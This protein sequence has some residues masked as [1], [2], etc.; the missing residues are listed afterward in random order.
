LRASPKWEIFGRVFPH[1]KSIP[2]HSESPRDSLE[3]KMNRDAQALTG[4]VGA[5]YESAACP[6]RWKYFLSLTARE[7][8]CEHAVLTMHDDGLSRWNLRQNS[9][10]PSEAI[11]EYNSYYG[12]IN[13]NITPLFQIARK[14]GSW[15]GLSRSLTGEREYKRSEYYN[16][17]GRK[18]GSYWGVMGAIVPS[19]HALITLSVVRP[20]EGGAPDGEAVRLMK[21]LMPHFGPVVKIHRMMTSLRSVVEAAVSGMDATEATM[22]A[23]D[24]DGSVVLM[25]GAAEHLLREADG[26]CLSHNRLSA[27]NPQESTKLQS[28]IQSATATGARRGVHPGGSLL[29][30]RPG[31]RPLQVSVVPFNSNLMLF[32]TIPCALIFVTDPDRQSASR[33]ALLSSLYQLTPAECRL[34]DLLI[35]GKDLGDVAESMRI[36]RGTARFMLKSIF[37]KTDTHRQSELTRFL[38]GLP[39]GTGAGAEDSASRTRGARARKMAAFLGG[40]TKPE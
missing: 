24:G 35:Q 21:L 32:D 28:L 5:F 34:A 10:L 25:N 1:G 12:A 16:D 23:V 3:G 4:L 6:E 31:R 39:N 26:L 18:Y 36:T 19:P 17:F 8:Q 15:C 20:E 11:D 40:K 2:I 9:G 14:A 37:R 27:K 29:L 33:A 38:L 22:F 7:M 13:P 30:H